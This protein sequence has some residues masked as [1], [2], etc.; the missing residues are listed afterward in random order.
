[1]FKYNCVYFFLFF[2]ITS[3]Y[4]WIGVALNSSNR[5]YSLFWLTVVLLYCC[6]SDGNE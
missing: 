1:M 6:E 3:M 5:H 4:A 2:L